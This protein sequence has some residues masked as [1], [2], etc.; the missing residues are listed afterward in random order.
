MGTQRQRCSAG[1]APC[2]ISARSAALI[3]R[4]SILMSSWPG[5]WVGVVRWICLAGA[6]RFVGVVSRCGSY[7]RLARSSIR[8]MRSSSSMA[9]TWAQAPSCSSPKH[10]I[11]CWVS[12][13]PGVR[14]LRPGKLSR[15]RTVTKHNPPRNSNRARRRP[16]ARPGHPN[17]Q[18]RP[19][20]HEEGDQCP[21]QLRIVVSAATA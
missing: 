11:Q 18:P 9:S 14:I 21:G 20:D 15:Q 17:G 7:G 19:R 3:P 5:C 16:I 4:P 8:F 1:A 13:R 10:P 2:A 12:T 6:A